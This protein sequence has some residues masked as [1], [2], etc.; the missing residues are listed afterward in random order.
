MAGLY[1]GLEE[2]A[3][4]QVSNG[5]VFTSCCPWLIG[6][7]RR[8]LVNESQ[9]A[10]IAE[11]IRQSLRRIK[12]FVFSAAI[13]IPLVLI[14]SIFWFAMSGATLSVTVVD[15]SGQTTTRQWIGPRRRD[16]GTVVGAAE[17]GLCLHRARLLQRGNGHC[18]R[19][20][21]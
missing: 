17:L 9:K 14:G 21:R 2:A 6:P 18:S 11:C 13:L 7:R 20:I 12:P 5:Y 3:F 19:T 16:S 15:A 10:E 1:D 4:K 8:Y